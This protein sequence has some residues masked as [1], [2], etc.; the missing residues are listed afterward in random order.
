MLRDGVHASVRRSDAV[1]KRIEDSIATLN[2]HLENGEDIYGVNT[3]C[4]G[5]AV[6]RTQRLEQLQTTFLQH[7]QSGIMPGVPQDPHSKYILA[8]DVTR[9]AMLIRCNSLLRGHSAIRLEMIEHLLQ[10]LNCNI[11]PL[12]P[13]RGSISASGDLSPLSYL[14]GLLEGNPDIYVR[15]T[16]SGDSEVMP[17]SDALKLIEAE[18]LTLRAKEAL[19]LMNGTA[20][21]AAAGALVVHDTSN[22]LILTQ[23][24]TA[25]ATEANLG[26]IDNYHHFI[27]DCR[28]HPGQQEVASN[29]R[30]LLAGSQFCHATDKKQQGLVQDRYSLRTAPQWIGPLLED[31]LL[32]TRQITTELNSTTDN[33]LIDV[34]RN[35]FHHGGN[36][37]AA[38][39]TVTMERTKTA[40]VMLGR[41]LASQCQEITNPSLNKGLSSNLCFD[42]PSLS[43]TCKGIEVNMISYLSELGYLSNSV[44]SHVQMAEL[45]NQGV[46]SLA[47][48]TARYASECADIVTMMCASQ[49]YVI[50][51]ALDL[52][53]FDSDFLKEAKSKLSTVFDRIFSSH[54][55]IDFESLWPEIIE[56]WHKT[57]Q[58]DAGDRCEKV[59]RESAHRIFDILATDTEETYSSLIQTWR[60]EMESSLSDI[61]RYTHESF[62]ARQTTPEY[63]ATSTRAMYVW[64][65]ETL[66]VPLHRGLVDHPHSIDDNGKE[67]KTIGTQITK[68]YTAI[69]NGKVV[70]PMKQATDGL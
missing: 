16:R 69:R 19:A 26:S 33:P 4:G 31:L 66:N 35:R 1:S 25:M 18:P 42:D 15:V 54:G 59:A 60:S 13:L 40:L 39:V 46:N 44:V 8:T 5:N 58:C 22:L 32:S 24:L 30:N 57:N 51:Q 43:F 49:L 28:P 62:S 65:R 21:S 64:V 37:Q 20:P 52:R 63:L 53:S 14:C 12:V 41:L 70:V 67:R 6:T 38:S 27:S 48:I 68:I 9:G 10:S 56:S 45:N 17:A 29:I 34:S 11:T 61:Y 50:C 3:G 23:I 47:L 36:F 55:S 2:R 7:H